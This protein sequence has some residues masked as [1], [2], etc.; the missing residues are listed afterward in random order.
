MELVY[1]KFKDIDISTKTIITHTNISF[2]LEK[3]FD[4]LPI[5]D[6]IVIPKRR[7]RKK[8]DH[9]ENV[10]KDI[11]SGSIVSMSFNGRLRGVDVKSRGSGQTYFRNAIAVV[12]IIDDKQFNF[13]ITANGKFQ[14]TG[15]KDENRAI[16]CMKYV[17][18]YISPYTDIYTINSDKKPYAIFFVVMTNKDF[19]L[20]FNINREALDKFVSEDTDFISLLETSFGYTGVNIKFPLIDKIDIDI[21]KIE[22]VD[23]TWEQSFIHYNDLF[24]I[25]SKEDKKKESNK[26]R[27]NTF[28]VFHSGKVIMS[29]LHVKHMAPYYA[30]F[31]KMIKFCEKDIKEVLR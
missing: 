12:I 25:M 14:M 6:Y 9:N 21:R 29:G 2:N 27:Y 19:V 4:I 7:G 1:P 28:L 15:C 16:K 10:N 22:L 17:W 3:L 18:D 26:E 31:I 5:T 13:K 8:K 23:G 20:P 24:E 11:A 30:K